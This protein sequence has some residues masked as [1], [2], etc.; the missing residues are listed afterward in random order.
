MLVDQF[1]PHVEV[2][3]RV[4]G[5]WMRTIYRPDETIALN[6]LDIFLS[7]DEVHFGIDFEEEIE[8]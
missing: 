4:E 8:E 2:Y 7:I 1:R 6:S 3:T 5:R